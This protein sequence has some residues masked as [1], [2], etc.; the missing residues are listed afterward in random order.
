MTNSDVNCKNVITNI[1]LLIKCDNSLGLTDFKKVIIHTF[2]RFI[3]PLSQR[4]ETSLP[5]LSTNTILTFPPRLQKPTFGST[6]I[7]LNARDG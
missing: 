6:F 5:P 7:T 3:K 4:F 1:D 2:N